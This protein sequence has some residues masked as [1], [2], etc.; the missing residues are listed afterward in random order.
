MTVTTRTEWPSAEVL[1]QNAVAM[2]VRFQ[3]EVDSFECTFGFN[4]EE[5]VA[6][7]ATGEIEETYEVCEW[8]M[9]VEGL[10]LLSIAG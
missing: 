9:A 5:L 10:R 6:K 8:L 4:T 7:L 1:A 3:A 2:R